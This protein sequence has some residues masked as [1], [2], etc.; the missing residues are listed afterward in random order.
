ME[1]NDMEAARYAGMALSNLSVN[2]QNRVALVENGGLK[3]LVKMANLD[4]PE[5]QR[6]AAV[7]LYNLSCAAGNHV[8]MVKNDVVAALAVLHATEDLE[9]KR[10]AV[11]TLANLASNAGQF[12]TLTPILSYNQT[13][14]LQINPT[15]IENQLLTLI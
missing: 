4:N 3:C 13:V 11:M 14:T 7:A 6:A 2:R 5:S 12:P 15:L 8:P 9:C 10:H 1:R